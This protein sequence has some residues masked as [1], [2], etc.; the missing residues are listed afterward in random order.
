MIYNF[1]AL[2]FETANNEPTSACSIGLVKVVNSEV[3]AKEV[4][5]INPDTYFLPFFT[6]SIH[7]ISAEHVQDAPMFNTV[8]SELSCL[9]QGA[10]FLV[11]HNASFDKR[12]LHNCCD[13]FGLSRPSQNFIC[14]VKAAKQ[15]WKLK[16]AKLD[17]VCDLL[18]IKLNHH[19]ALSDAMA[20]AQ[21]M[22]RALEHGYQ[23]L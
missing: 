12:V 19:E 15:C 18:G 3:V 4:R 23:V 1:V 20:S 21:I 17:L 2:D 7:G 8:W 22:L 11:A 16:S 14:T 10:D 9:L 5:L 13:S 6:N